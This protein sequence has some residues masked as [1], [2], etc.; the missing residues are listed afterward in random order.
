[1]IQKRLNNLLTLHCTLESFYRSLVAF[2]TP[3]VSVVSWVRTHVKPDDADH[4]VEPSTREK[5]V[6]LML[7][8]SDSS[9]CGFRNED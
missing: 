8:A 2:Q 5:A 4:M 1:L 7:T 9:D 6:N 3:I